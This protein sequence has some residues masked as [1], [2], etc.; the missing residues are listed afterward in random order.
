MTIGTEKR[1]PF[2]IFSSGTP[3]KADAL[4]RLLPT[5]LMVE[6]IADPAAGESASRW[7]PRFEFLQR[8]VEQIGDYKIIRQIGR[9][10]MGVVYEAYQE[11]L[12]RKVALKVL[13]TFDIPHHAKGLRR[14]QRESR[15][16]ANLHHSHIVPVFGVGD[17]LGLY[18]YVMQL[19]EGASLD[20]ILQSLRTQTET[21]TPQKAEASFHSIARSIVR[22]RDRVANGMTPPL[23]ETWVDPDTASN[24]ARGDTIDDVSL[25]NDSRSELVSGKD[26]PWNGHVGDW[27]DVAEIGRQLAA[28]LAYAHE[29]GVLHRDIKPSNLLVDTQGKVWLTDFGLATADGAP[30]V[31]RTGDVVGTL[32]YMA[33]EQ[34]EGLAD[35]RTDIYCLGA[36]L[37]EMLTLQ[38]VIEPGNV[39]QLVQRISGN[40]TA[41]SARRVNPGIPR[42]LDT[43]L[44]KML[45]PRPERRYTSAVELEADLACLLEDKPIRARRVSAAEKAWRWCRRNV[46]VAVLSA[47]TAISLLTAAAIG[48]AGY[49]SENR[50]R[51]KAEQTLDISLDAL[52][53]IYRRLAPERI[54]APTRFSIEGEHEDDAIVGGPNAAPI[55]SQTAELLLDILPA[56][57][58]FAKLNSG[59]SETLG[60][61]SAR[62]NA[63]VGEI[64]FWLGEYQL[65][66]SAFRTALEKYRD[67][68][69]SDSKQF[70]L[71]R[72]RLYNGIGL[73][74]DAEFRNED[75]RAAHQSALRLLNSAMKRKSDKSGE[76]EFEVARTLF[77]SGKGDR[78]G[79]SA[80]PDGDRRNRPPRH[81]FDPATENR[82]PGR[83][84]SEGFDFGG[85]RPPRR[86]GER[87][88]HPNVGYPTHGSPPKKANR[89]QLDQ[90]I[91]I[92]ERLEAGTTG[93]AEVKLL[94]A[95]CL[96][97]R[98]V[99]KPFRST[100]KSTRLLEELCRAYPSVADYHFELCESYAD[101]DIRGYV[102][103]PTRETEN[104]L[105][106]ALQIAKRL[107]DEHP[108]IPRYSQLSA[109]VHHK[110]SEV[111]YR[112]AKRRQ[113][114]GKA[115]VPD[116]ALVLANSACQIQSELTFEFPS[117]T[118][119]QLGLAR[120]L[121]AE[122]KLL[123]HR[124]ERHA[125]KKK[126]DQAIEG[127]LDLLKQKPESRTA[128]R[129]LAKLCYDGADLATELGNPAEAEALRL[130]AD[131][132]R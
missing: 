52:D 104:R 85:N 17:H 32:Q 10:G 42:D 96:R 84:T 58:Q 117:L 73:A 115:S 63:R 109:I 79:P 86:K 120:F 101:V 59:R 100:E 68:A 128:M 48:L 102:G 130:F 6:K 94:L 62:A 37:F 25:P 60:L 129:F 14:F 53:K 8:V 71:E 19:I 125:A 44:A 24:P 116:E 87:D 4:R 90:A 30:D 78:R 132:Y 55:S 22:D 92:L 97:E 15:A 91:E 43:I 89:K 18:Y 72:A 40:Q 107:Q 105:R 99:E 7:D 103:K 66:E 124:G 119:Y 108:N 57:D 41:P 29:Q 54:V 75:A 28:A 83:R 65:A 122:A 69:N 61:E 123:L 47:T 16:A 76:V 49:V 50:Q 77:L 70:A 51:Q 112:D 118:F 36:T 20:Q 12:G 114:S 64:Q 45:A 106:Q 13:P 80:E 2:R 26:T 46:A 93:N 23:G 121:E 35:A 31:T 127:L 82:R 38:P 39:Q 56:Y 126:L 3:S 88:R 98:D 1:L 74:A 21:E 11:S 111:L 81:P 95:L 110:L 131:Q 67:L 113:R 33:P 5:V 27:R 34:L 9:G